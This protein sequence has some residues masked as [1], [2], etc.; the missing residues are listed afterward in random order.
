MTTVLDGVTYQFHDGLLDIP[1]GLALRLTQISSDYELAEPKQVM[2]GDQGWNLLPFNPATWQKD[3]KKIIWDGPVGY[4]NGYGKASMVFMEELNKLIDLYVINSRWAGSNDKYLSKDLERILQKRTDDVDSYYV[5]FFP[6]FEFT[7]RRAERYIGYTMLECTRIPKSWVD[8]CNK[9]CE[10]VIVPCNQQKDAFVNSGVKR[11]VEVVPL[12]LQSEW[13]P[14]IERPD[15]DEYWFG[16]FGTLTYRKGTDLLYKA[17]VKGLDKK[18]YPDARL[19]VKTLPVGGIASLWFASTAEIEKDGRIVFSI[20]DLSPQDLLDNFFGKIDCFV[21]P[22]RGEG[23][24]MPPLEA[25]STGLP[26]ICTKFSGPEMF[27]NKNTGL[28]LDYTLVDVPNG[29]DG[30]KD[31][32]GYPAELQADGQQWAE[33]DLDQL[34]EHMRWCYNNREKAKAL[35]KNAS[36]YVQ[37]HYTADKSSKMLVSILDKRF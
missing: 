33:P 11:K 1:D 9:Y 12:G 15:E 16:S 8:N 21:F 18:N 32:R 24:G 17:F 30:K 6:A 35:G 37:T 7:K 27:I 31:F 3:Y 29:R 25:I 22:T 14:Y 19:Y 5:K 26:T 10:V 34:I 4:N 13:Y 2:G 23:M 20:D 28:P 36:K